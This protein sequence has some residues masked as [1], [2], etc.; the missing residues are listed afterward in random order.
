MTFGLFLPPAP[1]FLLGPVKFLPLSLVTAHLQRSQARSGGTDPSSGLGDRGV[2]QETEHKHKDPNNLITSGA[3][4]PG[5]LE[6]HSG[7]DVCV[8]RG[9]AEGYLGTGWSMEVFVV[10]LQSWVLS[11]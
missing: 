3:I 9:A 5:I 6:A 1:H 8:G 11:I 2:S 10:T 7:E 4:R